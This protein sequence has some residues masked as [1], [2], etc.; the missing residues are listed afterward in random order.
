MF[1]RKWFSAAAALAAACLFTACAA[2]PTETPLT[3]VEKTSVLEFAEPKVDAQMEAL[4]ASDYQGF[5]VDY[6][7]AMKEA[8]T[9]GAFEQLQIWLSVKV[10][11]YES[12]GVSSVTQTDTYY[13]VNYTAEFTKDDN[14]TMRVVFEKADPHRISGLWFDSPKLRE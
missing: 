11:A 7:A 9:F 12:R 8:T 2:T 1:L 13:I 4:A 14:V 10:G 6:D 5:L 3:E